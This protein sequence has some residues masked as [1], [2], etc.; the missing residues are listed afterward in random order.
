MICLMYGGKHIADPHPTQKR[1]TF[2]A[3]TSTYT[4]GPKACFIYTST[5]WTLCAL[6][7]LFL[8]CYFQ[9]NSTAQFRYSFILNIYSCHS[10]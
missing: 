8:L 4:L 2:H 7:C 1:N 5:L 6:T 3:G 9:T 10:F